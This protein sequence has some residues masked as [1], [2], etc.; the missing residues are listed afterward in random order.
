MDLALGGTSATSPLV[1]FQERYQ[2][3]Q[4]SA[5]PAQAS[6]ILGSC[7]PVP[8]HYMKRRPGKR[9]DKSTVQLLPAIRPAI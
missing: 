7:F 4:A 9:V 8:D 5:Q 1:K 3:S 2:A 6:S